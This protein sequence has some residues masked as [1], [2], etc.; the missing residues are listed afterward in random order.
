M[1]RMTP[2]T[3]AMTKAVMA[4]KMRARRIIGLYL[5]GLGQRLFLSRRAS[6]ALRMRV[7]IRVP[8]AN[9]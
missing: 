6:Q 2:A 3:A 8:R 7:E 1:L 4:R 5:S 9:T